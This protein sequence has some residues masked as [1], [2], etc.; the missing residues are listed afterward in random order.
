MGLG[1]GGFLTPAG[2]ITETVAGGLFAGGLKKK[3]G[4]IAVP[5]A[6]TPSAP[7]IPVVDAKNGT[8]NANSTSAA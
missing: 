2:A 8:G 6:N 4:E 5:A 1:L 7:A 3:D